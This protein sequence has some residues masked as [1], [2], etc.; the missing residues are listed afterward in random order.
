MPSI[1]ILHF[2]QTL[3]GIIRPLNFQNTNLATGAKESDIEQ[4]GLYFE[5]PVS[6]SLLEY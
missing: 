3:L 6:P 4:C 1:C 5:L 2:Q